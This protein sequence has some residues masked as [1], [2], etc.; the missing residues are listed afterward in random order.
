M[1]A[2]VYADYGWD[3]NTQNLRDLL[4]SPNHSAAFTIGLKKIYNLHNNQWLDLE[5][6][7]T[8]LAEPVDKQIRGSGYWYQYQGGYTNQS[9]IIGSGFGMGS[10]MQTLSISKNGGVKKLGIIFQ[11]IIHDPNPDSTFAGLP[12]A[13]FSGLRDMHW[14]DISIGGFF[15]QK[16]KKLILNAQLQA[17]S[18]KNYG[19]IVNKNLINFH[20]FLSLVYNW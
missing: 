4:M 10:N 1:H 17:I 8:H 20:F 7:I 12:S 14:A 6:E 16:F 2:E 11:R 19:W 5:A 9:R 3:D 13:D 15:Q 18:S